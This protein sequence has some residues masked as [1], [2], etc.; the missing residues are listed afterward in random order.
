MSAFIKTL[1]QGLS[2]SHAFSSEGLIYWT[3]NIAAEILRSTNEIWGHR[4][5]GSRAVV[6]VERLVAVCE[7]ESVS[8]SVGLADGRPDGLVEP[9]GAAAEHPDLLRVLP[10]SPYQGGCEGGWEKEGNPVVA[11]LEELEEEREVGS[12]EVVGRFQVREHA[13][14]PLPAKVL[15]ADVL[16][17]ESA[18]FL[19]IKRNLKGRTSMVVRRSNL[20][21]NCVTKIWDSTI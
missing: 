20:W 11:A 8:G 5:R 1:C 19:C 2:P 6:L 12:T 9:R 13:L 15:L 14:S 3:P 7:V 16:P 17:N 21:K 18:V 10:P 4:E